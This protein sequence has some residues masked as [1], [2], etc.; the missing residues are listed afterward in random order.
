MGRRLISLLQVKR[1][2]GKAVVQKVA[3]IKGTHVAITT[4]PLGKGE[5][6]QAKH[7]KARI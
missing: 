7:E 2:T 6:R 1:Q 4:Y 3:M 5:A